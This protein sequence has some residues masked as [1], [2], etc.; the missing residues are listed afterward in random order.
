MKDFLSET[1]KFLI[2]RLF[3]LFII[4]FLSFYILA[5][6]LFNMQIV[7]G[8]NTLNALSLTT[9]ESIKLPAPRGVILDK[10]GRPLA[11]N[12][13]AFTV[14]IDRSL[15]D[16]EG[17]AL[18]S[19][20]GT[21]NK[22]VV[23]EFNVNS[24]INDLNTV[25]FNLVKLFQKNG[26]TFIDDMPISTTEPFVFLE[27][28][29]ITSEAIDDAK[30]KD[31]ADALLNNSYFYQPFYKMEKRT[32]GRKERLFKKN[33]GIDE[34]L[35]ANETIAKLREKFLI[36][37]EWSNVDARNVISIR[38]SLNLKYYLQYEPVTLAS[39]VSNKTVAVLEEEN[40]FYHGVIVDIESL[41][42]YPTGEYMSHMLGYIG[43][44]PSEEIKSYVAKGY[45]NSDKVGISGLEKSFESDLKGIE[46]KEIVKVN[47]VNRRVGTLDVQEPIPGKKVFLTTDSYL[48]KKSFDF[49]KDM[50]KQ[51]LINK[52]QGLSPLEPRITEKQLFSS[53]VKSNS[54]SIGE[55][56]NSKPDTYSYK[57][58]EYI[59]LKNPNID[60]GNT[61]EFAL[62]KQSFVEA[63]E[64]NSITLREMLFILREQNLITGDDQYFGR[65]KNGAVSP[66]QVIIQKINENEIT[67]QMTNLDPSTGS[68]VVLDIS[69]G[70]TL[71]AV[72]YPSYD[73]NQLVNLM[74][75]D[76]Y[77]KINSDLSRP[78]N[79]RAFTDSRAPGSTFKMITA[80]AGLESGTIT[81]TTKIYDETTFV[82]AGKPYLRCWSTLSHGLINVSEALEV[83]CNYFFS[84]T[85][86][87]MGNLSLGTKLDSINKLNEYMIA[88]GLND[89]SGV[90]IGEYN[91]YG[92]DILRISSPELKQYQISKSKEK[93]SAKESADGWTDG[94][95]V[96]TAIGQFENRYSTAVMAKYTATLANGGKRYK[97][98]LLDKIENADGSLVRS[99][100]PI[101]ENI[102]TLK[103]STWKA[104]YDGML[105]VTTGR[106]G[107]A[108]RIFKDFPIV[109][110]GKTGTAQEITTRNDHASFA[111]FAPFNNPEIAVYVMIP[112][113]DTK[114]TPAPAAQIARDI[115]G[116]YMG[117]NSVIER[118][119]VDNSLVE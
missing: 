5:V 39:Y 75:I 36:P 51:I 14:K 43:N 119:I 94:N 62:A 66:L 107:T 78:L 10:Y 15:F 90:E 114:T 57:A 60:V 20:I 29:P 85:A 37:K 88:F 34:K 8:E 87:L 117:L 82:K 24:D 50:L 25:L 11:T 113:G 64:N 103:P 46:G 97:M 41:R 102:I 52:L 12:K 1:L 16:T 80:I 110:G 69:N 95:T 112:F 72:S 30:T 93:P 9:Q 67:P 56:F 35:T 104:V 109:V 77:Y 83:S 116:E 73:N 48:Q 7:E 115:I 4:I 32:I 58:K 28:S 18:T 19:N 31:I 76:Y 68:V 45:N 96:A 22:E 106:N 86:Y 55:I 44:I 6:R 105:L 33:M 63:I 26:E 84:E 101:V 23:E 21:L 54:I 111:G 38:Y 74:N 13:T 49:L 42:E 40:V 27:N 61:E 70:N 91:P 99:F 65:I 71:A 108:T 47:N 118:P 59:L 98:H 2:N 53:M 17:A 100:I 81:T 89:L 3:I 79:N 92:P